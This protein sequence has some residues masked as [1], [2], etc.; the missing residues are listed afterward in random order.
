M[1]GFS[2]LKVLGR[3]GAS[4]IF[5]YPNTAPA[6]AI[7]LLTRDATFTGPPRSAADL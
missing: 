6:R 1:E 7:M 2:V 4:R 5:K 3:S